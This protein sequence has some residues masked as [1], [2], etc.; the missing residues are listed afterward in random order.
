M[1]VLPKA[2]AG[3]YIPP[4]EEGREGEEEGKERKW[5]EGGREEKEKKKG[6]RERER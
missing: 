4:L 3:L 6:M 1:L 5:R 2:R